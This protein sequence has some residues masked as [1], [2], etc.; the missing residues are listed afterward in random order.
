MEL[1]EQQQEVVNHINGPAL[2]TACPGAGKTRCLTERAINL[3][4]NGIN[5]KNLLCLTFTNKAAKEIKQRISKKLESEEMLFFIGTFHSFCAAI[6]RKYGHKIGYTSKFSILDQK[7]QEDMIMNI[8]QKMGLK[9]SNINIYDVLPHVNNWRENLETDQELLD[10]FEEHPEYYDIS[11]KYLEEIKKQNTIDFSGLLSE[12]VRLFEEDK[13][14]L[15]KFQEKYK[16]ILQDECQD[17]NYIQFY[18]MNKIGEK[19]K[20]VMIIGDID[21]NIYSFRNARYQ[22]VLDFKQMYD[23]KHFILDKNYRST[24]QIIKC[25]NNLIKHNS[26]HLTGEMETDNEEGQP[27]ICQGFENPQEEARWIANN[28]RNLVENYGYSYSDCAVLYRLNNLSLEIQI[29][30]SNQGIPFTVIGGPSFFDR[31]EIKQCI[32]ML[33]FLINP[34]DFLAFSKIASLVSGVGIKTIHNIEQLAI[35]NSINILEVCKNVEKYTDKKNTQELCNKINESFNFDYSSF[36]AGDCLYN[37][38]DKFDYM[39]LLENSCKQDDFEDR[40]LNVN[41][42]VNSATQFGQKNKSVEKYLQNIALISSSDKENSDSVSLQTI[43]SV[44]GLECL[45]VFSTSVEQQI[46]PHWRDLADPNNSVE[47]IEESRRLFYVS[48][49][50]AKKLLYVSYCKTRLQRNAKGFMS[51]KK[52][53]PSQFLYESELLKKKK[54]K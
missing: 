23:C 24:K 54:H 31:K 32:S 26:T 10:R 1:N 3:I 40:Q 42:L 52:C 46:M 50:R 21:Q 2:V 18:L 13:I 29:A 8:A 45:I 11:I 6:L 7:E 35:D 36:H 41:E 4:R 34:Q 16:F 17:G 20:N 37:I 14:L 48:I 12:T 19:Y 47:L 5:P 44:K 30:L 15:A 43:H 38:I 33:K 9:K 22:N 27:V 39:K 49:T 53:K 51:T 28:I 25:A